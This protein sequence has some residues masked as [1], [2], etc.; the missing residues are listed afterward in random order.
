MVQAKQHPPRTVLCIPPQV[1]WTPKM[2]RLRSKKT[3]GQ[4][5]NVQRFPCPRYN[6][7]SPAQWYFGRQ[8][9]TEVIAFPLAHERIS[10]KV[11]ANH[12]LQRW[13]K[14]DKLRA[15]ANKSSRPKPQMRLGQQVI[16]QHLLSKRWD[17]RGEIIEI[18]DNGRSYLVQINSRRYLRNY[19]FLRP[20]PKP[21]QQH[22]N[23]E[24][25]TYNHQG[26]TM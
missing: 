17:L 10:D 6:G 9:R 3:V 12:E 21:Q 13:K 15:H 26:I 5:I 11:I 4:N 8:Q 22:V 2:C 25:R 23:H 18:R 7:L 20:L 16:A 1:Q 24:R 19:R 14:A